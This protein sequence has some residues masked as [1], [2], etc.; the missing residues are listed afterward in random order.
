MFAQTKK[1]IIILFVVG[2]FAYTAPTP[3]AKAMDPV[4]IGIL[5]PI[6]MPY[7]V[8]IVN[9][10]VEGAKRTIPGWIKAGIQILNIF[11][12]PLG[13]LQLFLG[14]PFGFAGFGLENIVRGTLA[15]LMFM[16]EI[17]CMPLYFFGVM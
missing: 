14:W 11:R 12:L 4:T 5:A 17:L 15:P 2:L 3:K 7:A 13:L 10:S 9:Y 6:A 8:R 1:S 16:K